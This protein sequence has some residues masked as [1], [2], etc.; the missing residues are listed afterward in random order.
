M[1]LTRKK[2]IELSIELWTWLAETGQTKRDW[3]G[4]DENG[5]KFSGILAKC[6]LCEF[7]CRTS[8]RQNKSPTC[9]DCPYY[10]K[11]GYNCQDSKNPYCLWCSNNKV[12]KKK[13]AKQFLEQLK[14]LL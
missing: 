9:S 8:K 12:E 14:T 5:G 1:R 7:V 3:V 13:Y 6:F 10:Q 2:A 11:Y 4:W